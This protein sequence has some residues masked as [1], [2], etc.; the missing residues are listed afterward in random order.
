MIGY[1]GALESKAIKKRGTGRCANI[2]G[3]NPPCQCNQ[4][5]VTN[6]SCLS[7]YSF[8]SSGKA[9][10]YVCVPVFLLNRGPS[11]GYYALRSLRARAF[12]WFSMLRSTEPCILILFDSG[13]L[14]A[15]Y[16]AWLVRLIL[17]PVPPSTTPSFLFQQLTVA[18]SSPPIHFLNLLAARFRT[19]TF[20]QPASDSFIKYSL[21]YL[22]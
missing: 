2:S 6:L 11:G 9:P 21:A 16:T 10:P 22:A 15:C 5:T 1:R 3:N 12:L 19:G 17:L 7:G 8:Q 20:P 14:L 13:F 4:S 18:Q